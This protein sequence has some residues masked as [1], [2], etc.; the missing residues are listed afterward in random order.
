MSGSARTTEIA[1]NLRQR[2][3]HS[4]GK[5]PGGWA[6]S[7][8][9]LKTSSPLVEGRDILKHAWDDL[10]L[11]GPF[12]FRCQAFWSGMGASQS[13]P[14]GGMPPCRGGQQAM[15]NASGSACPVLQEDKERPV[16]NVYN[17]RIDGKK[18]S[19]LAESYSAVLDPKNNMPSVP[20]QMPAVGQR[21]LLSTERQQSTIPKGGTDGSWTYPSAQM[22]YNGAHLTVEV[23]DI[24]SNP[25]TP[26]LCSGEIAHHIQMLML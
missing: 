24:F 15:Q 19:S 12:T 22:F 11:K 20:N 25:L 10:V 23:A 6:A 8:W 18:S 13:A 17:Q 1:L 3:H 9:E 7:F 16:Y 26:C 5:R 14:P 21:Q 4:F 2:G